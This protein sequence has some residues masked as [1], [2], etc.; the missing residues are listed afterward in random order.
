MANRI[1]GVTEKLEACARKEFMTKGFSGASLRTIAYEAGTT[2][3]PIYTRYGDKEGLFAAHVRPVADGLKHLLTDKQDAYHN[4][5]VEEQEVLFHNNQQESAYQ[6]NTTVIIEYIYD[7]FDAFKLLICCAEGSQFASYVE[8]LARLDVEYTMLFI[9]TTGNDVFTSKRAS[10]PLLHMISS[11]YMH[12]F[13]EIVRNDMSKDEAL[14]YV[15]QIRRF[16]AC[17]WDDL[18][19]SKT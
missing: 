10:Q 5:P 13:F 1:E 19:N 17:G 8:E 16:Y 18:L 11:A 15:A 14:L 7:N 12:G 4:K 3:R 6:D 2:T 9:E